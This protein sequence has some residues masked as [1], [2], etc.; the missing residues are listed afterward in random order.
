MCHVV[1]RG[2]LSGRLL[3]WW[4]LEYRSDT[5]HYHQ[6]PVVGARGV[7]CARLHSVHQQTCQ[8][9]LHWLRG[10][11]H[12]ELR[13]GVQLGV[14]LD[15]QRLCLQRGLV[16]GCHVYPVCGWNLLHGGGCSHSGHVYQVCGWSLLHCGGRSHSCHVCLLFGWHLLHSTGR[17]IICHL[18]CLFSR[19]VQCVRGALGTNVWFCWDQRVHRFSDL[20]VFWSLPSKQRCG[21]QFEHLFTHGGWRPESTVDCRLWHVACGA[22]RDDVEQG[23]LLSDEDE[24]SQDLGGKHCHVQRG[25]KCELCH[26]THWRPGRQPLYVLRHRQVLVCAAVSHCVP[27]RHVSL[28]WRG[29]DT[30]RGGWQRS[31]HLLPRGDLLHWHRDHGCKHVCRVLRRDLLHWH[32]DHRGQRMCFLVRGDLLHGDWV[33]PGEHVCRVLRRD[34]L[35][36]H[37]DHCGKRVCLL[38]RGDLLHW[39]RADPG[40]HVCFV[41]RRHLL[42]RHRGECVCQVLRRDLLYRDWADPRQCVCSLLRRDVLHRDWAHPGEP[43]CFVLRRHLLHRHRGECVCRVLRRDLLHWDRADP[44]QCV[45]SLLCRDLLHRHR[46]HRG[47]HVC[48]VLRRDLL[49]GPGRNSCSSLHRLCSWHLLCSGS[50]SM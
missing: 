13:L 38:F 1:C 14:H 25:G 36:W 31:V 7:H 20:D 30:D 32:R 47:E 37:R 19:H 45:C 41:H 9:L 6:H 12:L 2:I 28:G 22:K 23:R 43:V 50:N 17:G 5:V 18:H 35:H 15:G 21:Q 33:D 27:G 40:E 39:D 4:N 42:H 11:A 48:F 16:R 49:H 8:C 34:L 10:G 44:R 46:D 24:R 3:H 29:G 26:H